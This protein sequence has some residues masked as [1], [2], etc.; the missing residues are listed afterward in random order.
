MESDYTCSFWRPDDCEG[1]PHCPPRCPR[2]VAPDGS[3]YTIYS[4]EDAIEATN[5]RLE[6]K[7]VP[8]S[9]DQ[10]LVAIDDGGGVAGYASYEH[11]TDTGTI[12]LS[13]DTEPVVGTE[14]GRHLIAHAV[15]R[16]EVTLTVHGPEA[17]LSRLAAELGEAAE[18]DVEAELSDPTRFGERIDVGESMDP[19][20]G[21]SS[22]TVDLDSDA[23]VRTTRSPDSRADVQA[24]PD[25][26]AVV[27][28]EAVAVVGATDREGAIGRI[29]LENLIE[30]FDGDVVPVTPTRD[31]V[32]GISAAPSLSQVDSDAV[33]LA[34]VVLPAAAA[35]DVVEEAGIAGIDAVAVLSAGFG[36]GDADGVERERA[37][38][39]L[40]GEYGLKVV[41]PNSL[42]ILSTRAGLNASFAP[43][44]PDTGGVSILSHSGAMVTAILDWAE[45]QG[46]GVRDVVSLGN[47]AGIDEATLLRHWGADPKTDV[48][49]TYLED[50]AD[51]RAFVETAR[52]VTRSTPVVA[53]KSGRSDAGAQAAA[54]HTGALVGDDSGFD[55]AFD[56]AGVVRVRSQQEL[57]D[58]TRALERQPLPP[59]DR[60][61][62]VTNA[63]GPGVLA[64]DAVADAGLSL[65]D[66]SPETEHRLRERLPGTA[67]A[68]NPVDVLGDADVERFAEAL[69]VVLADRGV[70]AAIVVSTPHPLVSQS[71]LAA[72]IGDAGR[73]H[74]TPVVTCFSGGPLEQS[75]R[76]ALAEASVPN[77][78]DAE[79]ASRTLASMV[80]Y[81]KRR[82]RPV[83]SSKPIRTDRERVESE[84]MQAVTDGRSTLGVDAMGVLEA[85]G[86][87]TPDEEFVRSRDEAVSVANRL[88]ERV[89]LKI[90]SP[91]IAHKTDVG[92]VRVG[93]PTEEVGAAYDDLLETVR[94]NAPDATIRGVLVQSMIPDGLECLAGVTRHPRFG[95]L[96][97][98]GLGGIFVEHLEA[99]VHA[100]APL[101]HADARDLV[102]SID[103]ASIFDGARGSDPVDVDAL[104]DALVRLSWL[105]VEFPAIDELEINPLIATPDGVIALDLHAHLDENATGGHIRT[106]SSLD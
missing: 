44:L 45:A 2:Y 66:L 93:V 85:Y 21:G 84:L 98:F 24:P 17:S 70:D 41:G 76:D 89:V 104:A 14:L 10:T 62:V 95:P 81:A 32:L 27:D 80:T 31:E 94:A 38:R 75:V 22:L 65:A 79:R 60:I 72:A 36:E 77:Y 3:S 52:E 99:V 42:G 91:D 102:R 39:E 4:L 92:G 58:L 86:I 69:D 1:T 82:R 35:L 6:L 13:H 53:L 63:G 29:V 68:S 23:A 105:A 88:G 49:L 64:A 56:S 18:F 33:D 97:T 26:S 73:R 83:E 50:V 8:P 5:E 47:G 40:I 90:A 59:G 51:G 28:P 103:A 16:N 19:V 96:V 106:I 74:G 48:V 71:E 34:V 7:T 46:V 15:D 78:S 43:S 11:A 20:F 55:A 101:S 61:A 57:Y 9:T 30:T 12:E 100:L 87:S 54:S 67:T 37:L 25:I